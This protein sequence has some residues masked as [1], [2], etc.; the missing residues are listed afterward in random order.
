M[1]AF[2]F[3]F[4]ASIRTHQKKN[5]MQ[6]NGV[7]TREKE[8]VLDAVRAAGYDNCLGLGACLVWRLKFVCF[9]DLDTD[10]PTVDPRWTSNPHHHHGSLL[11]HVP[12][13]GYTF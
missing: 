2:F 5:E 9:Q 12:T 7:R 8:D 13:L 6:V 4:F 10:S 11:F 1:L 3:G